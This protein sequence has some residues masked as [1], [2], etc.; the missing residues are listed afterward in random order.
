MIVRM[1]T[2]LMWGGM[3][4]MAGEEV[5]LPAEIAAAYIR[6]NQAELIEQPIETAA[7]RTTPPKGKYDA[8]TTATR[9]R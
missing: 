2:F 9:T 1:T 7:L 6:S 3:Q 4:Y 8:R 5:D